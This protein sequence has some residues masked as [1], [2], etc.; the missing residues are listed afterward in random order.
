MNSRWI[1]IVAFLKENRGTIAF[2][3]LLFFA[4]ELL[5][6]RLNQIVRDKEPTDE[7][8]AETYR[9]L[10]H[11][12]AVGLLPPLILGYV[13]A[14]S[15]PVTLLG[16]LILLSFFP[17]LDHP[18]RRCS[19][20]RLRLLAVRL[21]RCLRFQLGDF[22]DRTQPCVQARTAVR[23][24]YNLVFGCWRIWFVHHNHFRQQETW[25]GR[26][27]LLVV[28]VACSCLGHLAGSPTCSAT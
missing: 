10:G 5:A 27:I 12:F 11:W 17:I 20:R 22:V 16:L 13:L 1:S 28:R 19:T 7:I 3:F 2:L 21:R 25:W 6:Y 24:Q 14:P 23:S 26:L 15:A 18:A 8:E 4:S 9:I